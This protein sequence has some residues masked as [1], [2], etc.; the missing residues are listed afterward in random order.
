MRAHKVG[1]SILER[2][3]IK[4]RQA[5]YQ[6][7]GQ[8]LRAEFQHFDV[9]HDGSLSYEEFRHAVKSRCPLTDHEMHVIFMAFDEDCSGSIDYH[10]FVTKL[11]QGHAKRKAEHSYHTQSSAESPQPAPMAKNGGRKVEDEHCPFS[12]ASE[13]KKEK[14]AAL[15]RKRS[16]QRMRHLHQLHGAQASQ[17]KERHL[18]D[19]DD[20]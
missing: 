16:A 11:E 4:L 17:A 6:R 19:E 14:R 5:A 1:R 18:N 10:E 2:V 20:Y 15:R 12:A 8:D 7:G 13:K 3:Q 9:N